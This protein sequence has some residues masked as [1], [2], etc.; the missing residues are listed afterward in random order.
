M[1][2][3]NIYIPLPVSGYFVTF[4]SVSQ[5][6]YSHVTVYGQADVYSSQS[7]GTFGLFS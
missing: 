7:C 5:S 1:S 2:G 3:A 6:H 4:T